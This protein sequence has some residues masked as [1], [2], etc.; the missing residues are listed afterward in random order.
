M[1]TAHA[2]GRPGAAP[3]LLARP[4]SGAGSGAGAAHPA[5]GRAKAATRGRQQQSRFIPGVLQ[6][7]GEHGDGPE[8]GAGHPG[9]ACPPTG[10]GQGE[11][12]G[13]EMSWLS[14]LRVHPEPWWES[15]C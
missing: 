11:M 7:Q 4:G 9:G 10:T 2:G 15:S 13:V 14:L 1:G 6:F 8:R 12:L 5:R 3:A